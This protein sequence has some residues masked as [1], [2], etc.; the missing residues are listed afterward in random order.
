MTYR[1]GVKV[2]PAAVDSGQTVSLRLIDRAVVITLT[3][4][5]WRRLLRWSA[6]SVLVGMGLTTVANGVTRAVDVRVGLWLIGATVTVVV[7]GAIGAAVA[8]AF[9]WRAERRSAESLSADQVTFARSDAIDGRVTVTVDCTDG[10]TRQ[11]SASGTAGPRTAQLFARM[12]AAS[13]STDKTP[14]PIP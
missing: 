5:R 13:A 3:A 2:F 7:A 14:T 4:P 11:F 9:I 1:I 10:T 8:G 12:L 6:G